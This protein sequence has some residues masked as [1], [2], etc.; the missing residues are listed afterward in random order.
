[1][2]TPQATKQPLQ[3][4]PRLCLVYVRKTKIISK[5]REERNEF[6]EFAASIK[7]DDTSSPIFQRFIQPEFTKLSYYQFKHYGFEL[8]SK[9]LLRNKKIVAQKL[10]LVRH[11]ILKFDGFVVYVFVCL[12]CSLVQWLGALKSFSRSIGGMN[13]K[14]T[15]SS[16]PVM[17]CTRP[18]SLPSWIKGPAMRDSATMFMVRPKAAK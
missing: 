4:K 1:M 13:M 10:H 11:W 8:R 2:S 9:A 17:A 14:S 15:P 5:V 3:S 18:R 6:Y 7:S 16:F 12:N